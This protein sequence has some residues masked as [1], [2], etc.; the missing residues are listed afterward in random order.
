M[1]GIKPAVTDILTKLKSIVD[2]NSLPVLQYVNIWNNQVKY[3]EEA[4]E[5]PFSKP[6]AFVEVVNTVQYEQLGLGVQTADL[7][8]KIHLVHEFYDSEDGD[9]DKNLAVYDVRDYIVANLSFFIPT[10]CNELIRVSEE[11]DDNH[12]NIFHFVISFV[13][14]LID[15]TVYNKLQLGYIQ[16]EAPT[17][18]EMDIYIAER[19]VQQTT[20]TVAA[21]TE[22]RS[23]SLRNQTAGENTFF[24]VDDGGASIAGN[25]VALV[26]LD[27]TPL[28]NNQWNW[29][30]VNGWLTITDN[31]VY[32]DAGSLLTITYNKVL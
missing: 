23:T 27:I 12:N 26:I 21:Q 9:F 7:G 30:K 32:V 31:S 14:N 28:R 11:V 5:Y 2:G 8:I 18:L 6:A 19:L 22:V 17:D 29:D 3:E 4:K 25:T 1:A 20:Y 16:K 10:G 24:I 15:T 13:T